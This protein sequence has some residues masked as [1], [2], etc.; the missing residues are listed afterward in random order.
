MASAAVVCAAD[1]AAAAGGAEAF[2]ARE[3]LHERG[4]ESGDAGADDANVNFEEG[5][6]V[7]DGLVV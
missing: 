7:G 4:F 1:V 2:E 3:E 5:P 6:A